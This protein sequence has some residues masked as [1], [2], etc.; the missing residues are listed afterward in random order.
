MKLAIIGSRTFDDWNLLDDT[1]WHYFRAR[2]QNDG[3]LT[4]DEI[5]SGGARGAD[6]MAAKWAREQKVPLTEFLPD[7]DR[8]GKRAGFIR[9]EDIIKSA[10]VVLCFWDGTSKGAANSLSIA[11]RLKK[12]TLIIY[13]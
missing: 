5:I 10:D 13:F 6:G 9:N 3:E 8:Y 12:T 1:I 4:F 7:W 11:K 2:G